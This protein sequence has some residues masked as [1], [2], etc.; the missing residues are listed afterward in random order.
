MTNA[1]AERTAHRQDPDA[2][3]STRHMLPMLPGAAG[4]HAASCGWRAE[5]TKTHNRLANKQEASNL[6]RKPTTSKCSRLSTQVCL[7][8][9]HSSSLTLNGCPTYRPTSREKLQAP[10]MELLAWH[11]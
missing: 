4:R 11:S 10:R 1:I 5:Q 7:F 2:R 9:E 8:I 6:A 3:D